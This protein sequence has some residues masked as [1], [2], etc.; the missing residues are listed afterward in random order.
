MVSI[1]VGNQVLHRNPAGNPASAPSA[2]RGPSCR[3]PE[4][5]PGGDAHRAPPPASPLR[6]L[7]APRARGAWR[8]VACA[9]AAAFAVLAA[10]A[11]STEARAETYG[12][13][14]NSGYWFVTNMYGFG[15]ADRSIPCDEPKPGWIFDSDGPNHIR[16]V[17]DGDRVGTPYT[18]PGSNVVRTAVREVQEQ[19]NTRPRVNQPVGSVFYTVPGS[20]NHRV[21]RGTDGDCY[22]EQRIRG[23]WERSNS[24]GS[25]DE[26]CRKASWNAYYRS[27]GLPLLDPVDG[28]F[29]SGSPAE[30]PM[31]MSG[32]VDGSTL[33]LTFD[34]SLNTGLRPPSRWAFYVTVNSVRRYVA[35]G[36]VA[37]SG[38]TVR[39]TLTSAAGAGDTVRVRYTRPSS[40]PL[41]DTDGRAVATFSDRAVTN[42]TPAG[43]WSAML[44]V[45]RHF[46]FHG[47]D[48]GFTGGTCSSQLTT[49]SFT[50]GS[51]PYRILGVVHSDTDAGV[52]LLLDL[53]TAI[54]TGWTLHVGDRR[55]PVADASLSDSDKIATWTEPGF[56]WTAG[57]QVS[58]RLTEGSS[59]TGVTISAADA[60][61]N[62]AAGASVDFEVSLSG[63]SA[64]AVTVDYATADGTAAAGADYTTT[65]GTLTFASGETSKTVSVPV[66]DDTHDE[67]EET[68]TLTLSNP[69]GATIA[70]SEATG[71]IANEDPA[72]KA[73]I[74]RFGRTVA[75]QV[76]GAV[77]ARMAVPRTGGNEVTL[78]G[79]RIALDATARGAGD[80]RDAEAAAAERRLAAWLRHADPDGGTGPGLQ[81]GWAG[82]PE[83]GNRHALQGQ[84]MTERGLLL[85][86]SFS[87][88]A[89]DARTGSYA[90]WG[91]GSVSRFDGREGGL[92]VDGEV[93]SAFLGA[94]WSRERT[95]LGLILGHSIGDGGY[96]SESGRGTASSTLTGLY[97]W[98]RQA[99]GERVSLWGVA[100]YGEGTLTVTPANADGTSQAALRTDLELA[101][102]AVG[103]HGT[104]VQAPDEGG[105][106][107]AVKTD[108]MGVRTRS[109]S[110]PGLAGA[111][112]EVTRLQAG[113]GGLA[114]VPLRGRGGAAA[115]RR[116][117]GA[118]GRRRRRDRLRG[119]CRRRHRLDGPAARKACAALR[120]HH[121][122][123][124]SQALPRLWRRI[125][126]K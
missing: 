84:G 68:F 33:T 20:S 116:G 37:I 6:S 106:E 64:S 2:S 112:A 74:A 7:R 59:T 35:L 34:R 118:P 32:T 103:L 52:L 4:R 98:V 102:G 89:G 94:D 77:E 25:D 113:P 45:V 79:H 13:T 71:A 12:I 119:G 55:F 26:A 31:L 50:H 38:Q 126:E 18:N 101:M 29:P 1:H 9:L 83:A 46:D 95:T 41:R 115:E 110:A 14:C 120:Q 40:N 121:R 105:F 86:S 17:Y 54:P 24:F 44:T 85:G 75:E 99:L 61:A 27:Q 81:A 123:G 88:A 51:T 93:A 90:L 21:V 22:R 19:G 39:L 43:V 78:G 87:L 104:L 100:G 48:R 65:S 28:T 122:D 67:G 72:P 80:A 125:V 53:D 49:S 108:A 69:T 3:P 114:P 82:D 10:F 66:L 76:I 30:V 91:R 58:L 96:R 57:Q 63:A 111:S 47:C 62:E 42:D 92:A 8:A 117:R 70:D 56:S 124:H 107:L 11:F 23:Q 5:L 16:W 60:R 15:Y 97:P 109:A 73:W 36:G